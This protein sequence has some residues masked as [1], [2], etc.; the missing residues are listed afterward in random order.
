MYGNKFF[1]SLILIFNDFMT[2]LSEK[3]YKNAFETDI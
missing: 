2:V 3:M 1:Y